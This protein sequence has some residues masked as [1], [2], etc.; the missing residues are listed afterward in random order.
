MERSAD[1]SA[2][3]SSVRRNPTHKEQTMCIRIVTFQLAGPTDQQYRAHAA[4]VAPAFTKWP[5]LQAK[6]WLANPDAGVYGGVYLFDSAADADASRSTEVFTAMEA[7]PAFTQLTVQEFDVLEAPTA[8]TTA[9]T[10]T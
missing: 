5:G 10:G 2:A 4:A 8:I 6:F 9:A 7:N 1:A 3:L